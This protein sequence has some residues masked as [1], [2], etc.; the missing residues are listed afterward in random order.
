MWSWARSLERSTEDDD[1][2]AFVEV[3]EEDD[4]EELMLSNRIGRDVMPGL[5][6]PGTTRD[7]CTL[8]CCQYHAGEIGDYHESYTNVGGD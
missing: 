5:L 1:G 6:D 3:I 2:D 7:E 4:A 8:R